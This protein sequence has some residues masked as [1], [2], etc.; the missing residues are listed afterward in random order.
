MSYF[1]VADS[2]YFETMKIPVREGRTFTNSDRAGAPLVA[3]V[4]EVVARQWFPKESAV[5]HVIKFGG[6]YLPGPTLEIVG[7]VGNVSQEGMDTAPYPEIYQPFAQHPSNAMVAMVRT[8]GDSY[9]LAPAVRRLVTSLDRNLPIQK[10]MPMETRLAATLDRRRFATLLLAIFAGLALTLSAVG[11]YG[12]LNYWVTAREEEI[13]IR[14]A[15]GARRSA[16]LGWAGAAVSK[17]IGAGIVL[18]VFAAWGASHMLDSLVFG[19]SARDAAMMMAS[20]LVVICIAMIAAALPLARATRV[21]AA[22]KLQ[23]A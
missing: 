9:S 19:V 21:D 22:H 6:P 18:G 3:V 2:G 5:G 1:N 23:R 17:L 13:A 15:L 12:L 10:L 7:V 8:A 14:L 4:N 20:V 11:V 16:I